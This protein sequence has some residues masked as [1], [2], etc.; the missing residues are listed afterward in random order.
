MEPKGCNFGAKPFGN[1]DVLNSCRTGEFGGFAAWSQLLH[2]MQMGFDEKRHYS[3]DAYFGWLFN[4]GKENKPGYNT[5]CFSEQESHGR[6]YSPYHLY[7]EI[8]YVQHEAWLMGQ[9]TD[10][11]AFNKG[12]T[13]EYEKHL[14]GLLKH[15]LKDHV[16]KQGIIWNQKDGLTKNQWTILR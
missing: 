16:D 8:C 13:K 12:A 15:F 9:L 1:P 10:A 5:L 6:H 4:R 11:V 3:V 7:Q 2:E 14:I